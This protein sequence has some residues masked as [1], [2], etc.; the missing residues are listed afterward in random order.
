MNK[1]ELI[2]NNSL[3]KKSLIENS[4]VKTSLQQ[5]KFLKPRINFSST[6][7]IFY[8]KILQKF[9]I[10]ALLTKNKFVYSN[11]KFNLQ[12]QYIYNLQKDFKVNKI[13]Y[14]WYKIYN[15]LACIQ[16]WLMQLKKYLIKK[17]IKSNYIIK[18]NK[19]Q[20]IQFSFNN[21]KKK[22]PIQIKQY[23]IGKRLKGIVCIFNFTKFIISTIKKKYFKNYKFKRIRKHK[24]IIKNTNK[25]KINILFFIILKKLK[26][27]FSNNNILYKYNIILT[28]KY[29]NYYYFIKTWLFYKYKFLLLVMNF[30][31]K[32]KQLYFDLVNKRKNYSY[33]NII[34]NF[35]LVYK[36]YK[37][38]KILVHS[39]KIFKF[40]INYIFFIFYKVETSKN[41]LNNKLNVKLD[42]FQGN[43]PIPFFFFSFIKLDFKH[44]KLLKRFKF[45]RLQKQKIIIKQ[46]FK[47]IIY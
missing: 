11:L 36:Q 23:L 41:Y 13:K 10:P 32:N 38:S 40:F 8:Y 33:L 18:L 43:K 26:N 4:I 35:I 28:L 45:L 21:K 9:L 44:L 37:N 14:P 5:I 16:N 15:N 34:N 17:K 39:N 1:I 19:F 24:I 7:K 6:K 46:F 42:S 27:I 12:S 47:L 20:L 31:K 30:M 25:I 22:F 3:N 2:I 29:Y